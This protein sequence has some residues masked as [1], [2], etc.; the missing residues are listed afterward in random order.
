MLNLP[1]VAIGTMIA[2]FIAGLVSLL[3]LIISKEQKVSEFRQAWIDALRA[4]I[5]SLTRM[6]FMVTERLASKAVQELGRS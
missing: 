1:D 5:S 2:A 6:P 4:E 3:S